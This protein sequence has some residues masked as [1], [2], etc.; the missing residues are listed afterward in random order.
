[1]N[2]VEAYMIDFPFSPAP[3]RPNTTPTFDVVDIN[4]PL[5]RDS[6]SPLIPHAWKALLTQHP[7]NLGNLLSSTLLYGCQIGY[8]GPSR[9]AF[10][11]NHPSALDHPQLVNKQLK[12][13]LEQHRV[14]AIN[15][16][17][18]PN[19]IV[20]PLGAVPKPNGDMRR[21][22]NLSWPYGKGVN[23]HIDEDYTHLTMV[24]FEEVLALIRQAGQD[25]YLIKRDMKDA[26]RLI[27]FAPNQY[28]LIAFEWEGQHYV[29]KVLPFGLSTAPFIFNLFAEAMHW[30]L[31]TRLLLPWKHYLDDFITVVPDAQATPEFL[32]KFKADYVR[33]I[34]VV[35]K[36]DNAEKNEDGLEINILG[37]LVNT[38]T[39]TLSVPPLKQAR[40]KALTTEFLQHKVISLKETQSLVGLLAWCAP[41]VQLGFLFCRRL[42]TFIAKWNPQLPV[43]VRWR[44]P[45][46][47]LEDIRWWN[48]L[49]PTHNGVRLFNDDSRSE[50]HLFCDAQRGGRGGFF[51]QNLTT[52]ECNWK[53][54]CHTVPPAHAFAER[55]TLL[56]PSALFDINIEEIRAILTA[57]TS[58]ANLW[59]S[60][61]VVVHTDNTSSALGLLKQTLRLPE[62]FEPL[63]EVLL[64]A[65]QHDILIEP[66]HIAGL[67]NELADALSRNY[68]QNIANWCPHWQT[69]STLMN[70]PICS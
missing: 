11:A 13:D 17:D 53:E 59:R 30:I 40:I 60:S 5:L 8:D 39:S 9:K 36:R 42:W 54:H 43:F 35:G 2:A 62:Q 50:I 63:R 10:Y 27:P 70:P 7:G 31:E 12:L 19:L 22:H 52:T 25:C 33:S 37:L 34:G 57:F 14:M 44:I 21:I 26:F 41:A 49:F 58:W 20:S 32:A 38:H 18:W 29:E 6:P 65:A 28:W 45:S 4:Q 3:A 23:Q 56:E 69:S 48:E 16:D 51:I 55:V 46:T 64:K 15:P 61:K 24:A 66:A 67:D 68:T 1:M 47:V